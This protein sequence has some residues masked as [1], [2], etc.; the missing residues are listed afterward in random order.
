MR[1]C[2]LVP[3]TGGE[4]LPGDIRDYLEGALDL[5]EEDGG[6]CPLRFTARQREV[7]GE[8]KAFGIR[9]Q[10]SAGICLAMQTDAAALSFSFQL[11]PG[12][13]QDFYSFDLWVNGELKESIPGSL[14]E[15]P[16]GQLRFSLPEGS[17]QVRLYLPTLQK[18]VLKDIRI[19]AASFALPL[20][21]RKKLLCLGDSITQGYLGHVSSGCYAA[22]LGRKMNAEVIN[23]GIGGYFFDHRTLDPALA[24]TADYVMI[25]YGTNDWAKRDAGALR[26]EASRYLD[27]AADLFSGAR[28]AVLTPLP[29][30]DPDPHPAWPLQ[31]AREEIRRLAGQHAVFS[32]ID[33]RQILPGAPDVLSP[34]GI[35]PNDKGFAA[36]AEHL[37]QL[38]PPDWKEA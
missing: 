25:A 29:R 31:A 16:E 9:A 36:M 5:I 7:Y 6:I 2:G 15:K 3:E 8:N 32:V 18:T 27:K 30:L 19:E 24:L 4:R 35:H 17:K 28:A 37:W 13:S 33:G 12:S 21:R 34:D 22:R 38:L 23:Q 20:P 1:T 10:A 26:E 11:G 14:R